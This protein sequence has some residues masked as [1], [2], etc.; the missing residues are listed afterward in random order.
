MH[1]QQVGKGEVGDGGRGEEG[2]GGGAVPKYWWL[3][4]VVDGICS[5][6]QS[7]A[8]SRPS[9]PPQTVYAGV[10]PTDQHSV[11]VCQ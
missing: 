6:G 7:F 10:V 4:Q 9:H 11:V 2:G 1:V 8:R 3:V 5:L